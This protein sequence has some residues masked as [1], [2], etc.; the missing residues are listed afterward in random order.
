ME[1]AA[2]MLSRLL[3]RKDTA[4]TLQPAFLEWAVAEIRDIVNTE[5]GESASARK[6]ISIS[7]TLRVNGAL[8]ALCHVFRVIGKRDAL[9]PHVE[10]LMGI[11]HSDVFEQNALTR[12][13]IA[14][15]TQRLVLLSLPCSATS[16]A[17]AGRVRG[18]AIANL[19]GQKQGPN[20][21]D[22]AELDTGARAAAEDETLDVDIPEDAEE[23]I[24]ILLQKLHDKDTIVRWSAAKGIGRIAER[25]PA[26]L[27]REITNAVAEVLKEETLCLSDGTIDV[28]MTSEF[29]WHGA[30]LCLAELSRR[31]LLAQNTLREVVPWIIRGLT[32]EIQ[33]GDY[34]VGSNVRDAAC[35]TMWSFARVHHQSGRQVFSEMRLQMATA[36]VSVAVFDREANVRRA[37][38]A[39]FQE[40]VGR[41]NSFPH[42]IPVLQLADFFSVGNMRSA[43]VHASRRIAGFVEY[44]EPLLRHLCTITIYHW[45]LKTRELAAEALRGLAPLAADYVVAE[46]LPGIVNNAHSPFL[47][48]RHGAIIATGTIAEALAPQLT[49]DSEAVKSVLSVAAEIP[50]RFLEDFGANLTLEALARYVGSLSRSGWSLDGDEAQH[51]FFDYFVHALTL[52]TNKDAVVPEFTAFVDRFGITPEQRETIERFTAAERSASSREGFVLALGA[53]PDR[54]CFELVCRLVT[55]GSSVEI[56]RNAASALG[57]LCKRGLSS[58]QPNQKSAQG[59]C[60]GGMTPSDIPKAAG[61]LLDGLLDHTVDSR[62]D[63][64][65]WVRKQCLHSLAVLFGTGDLVLAK[66]CRSSH[67]LANRLFERSLNAATE[68]IDKLRAAAGSL[69]ES[70]LYS[71]RQAGAGDDNGAC[72]IRP[73]RQYI[74]DRSSKSAISWTEPEAAFGQLVHAL[75]VPDERL[76]RAL[77]EG[78]IATGSTEPLGKFAVNAVIAYAKTLPATDEAPETT[79]E[80]KTHWLWSA[81]GMVGELA[82]LLLTDKRT[83]KIINPALIVADQLI[84]QGALMKASATAWIPLYRAVQRLAYKLRAPYRLSLCLKL[85]ASLSLVSDELLKLATSSLV[86]HL[87]HPVPK[88]RQAAADHLFTVLCINGGISMEDIGDDDDAALESASEIEQL[89]A[90]TEWMGDGEGTRSAHAKLAALVKQFV[91]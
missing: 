73:L 85:Y 33:R 41:H 74:P 36:L 81:D 47:A 86:A 66:L 2:V 80:H 60:G 4:T 70:L 88:I 58:S 89:L 13:L 48:V 77:F 3:S 46:L 28:S 84:E 76:R 10:S 56:R 34:S 40:H 15:A 18:S 21:S 49:S 54:K 51:R 14:K 26:A 87:A 59:G 30:L 35:Y 6:G 16:A 50:E 71:Q 65:S 31:G 19:N 82:R 53:L 57:Q 64:G 22:A 63:V 25:L 91:Q 39:A 44:R 62:G 45:D 1:G 67:G 32:Y 8:R 5:S 17:I 83:S 38:S 68:K 52:C 23:F 42:G 75:S 37:A 27:A 79:A 43:F 55:E 29:S 7:G 90:E 69:L 9:G 20:N 24:G 61:A 72:F 11:F 12:K 78:F